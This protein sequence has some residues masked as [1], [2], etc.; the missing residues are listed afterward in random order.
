MASKH[1][2]R[3]TINMYLP[4]NSALGFGLSQVI[5]QSGLSD[6]EL[7]MSAPN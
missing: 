6:T 5:Q 7:P 4:F 2:Q 1:E 3:A